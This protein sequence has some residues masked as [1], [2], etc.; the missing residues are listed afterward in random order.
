MWSLRSKGHKAW[1]ILLPCQDIH[2]LH[3]SCT[4][5]F[6]SCF[7]QSESRGARYAN[8]LRLKRNTLLG[9][10]FCYTSADWSI[11][12]IDFL[13]YSKHF[14]VNIGLHLN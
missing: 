9:V 2:P 10:L 12:F 11:G 7:E 14:L 3:K 13:I 5:C 4:F 1:K 6:V 8:C